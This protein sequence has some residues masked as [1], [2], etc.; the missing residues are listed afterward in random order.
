M[1]S[2]ASA[3]TITPI[4]FQLAD[5]AVSAT[6]DILGSETAALDQFRVS[7]NVGDENA[8]GW[9]LFPVDY[10]ECT[11]RGIVLSTVARAIRWCATQ[12]MV[13]STALTDFRTRKIERTDEADV[14]LTVPAPTIAKAVD[15][16]AGEYQ[17]DG[18]YQPGEFVPWV[19]TVT[20]PEG[21]TNSLTVNDTLP[22]GFSYISGTVA[23]DAPTT[24][25]FNL[26][27]SP[28][29]GATGAISWTFSTVDVTASTTSP[30]PI[31]DTLSIR[32]LTRVTGSAPTGTA[33]NATSGTYV[34]PGS[35]AT[36]HRYR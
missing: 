36:R 34:P 25:V 2:D 17:A 30:N 11:Y 18:V 8:N 32:F 5:R 14:P 33:T 13:S 12:S 7:G 9:D 28:A 27:G 15:T 16:N 4:S 3:G 22:T 31:T 26:T 24:G 19:I 20:L 29:A 21:R 10:I 35:P 6:T 1:F 23:F